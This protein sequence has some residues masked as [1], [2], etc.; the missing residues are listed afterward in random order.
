M[1]RSVTIA[2]II[3][4]EKGVMVY[5]TTKSDGSAHRAVHL[6]QPDTHFPYE[7]LVV[8][9]TYVL[10]SIQKETGYWMIIEATKIDPTTTIKEVE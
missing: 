5:D 4:N 7:R 2:T 3:T 1:K 6:I 8:D 10:V 9:A